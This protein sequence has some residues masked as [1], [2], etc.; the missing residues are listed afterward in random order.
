LQPEKKDS[1]MDKLL[2]RARDED[3]DQKREMERRRKEIDREN[4]ALAQD[5]PSK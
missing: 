4:A 3:E 5:F 1:M 2:K